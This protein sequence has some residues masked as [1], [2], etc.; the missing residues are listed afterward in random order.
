MK[1]PLSSLRV[2]VCSLALCAF[3]PA[4]VFAQKVLLLAA[5]EPS[6]AADVQA[7][8]KGS[9]VLT[10]VDVLDVRNPGSTPTLTALLAYDA[11]LT[12]S[13]YEYGDAVGL[14]NV[15]ADYV[16]RGKGVVQAVFALEATVP[17]ALGGRWSSGGYG[18]FSGGQFSMAF[19][20]SLK[21]LQPQHPIL[22]GVVQFNSGAAGFYYTN[23]T[24]SPCG[25]VV[26]TWSNDQPLAVACAGPRGG[27]SVGLNMF[28]PSSAVFSDSWLVGTDGA[29]LMANALRYAALAPIANT[30][31]AADAGA[32]QII[33]ATGPGGAAF[34]LTA[35]GSD[36]DGDTLAF[37]WAGGAFGSGNLLSGTLQP[38][39]APS[40][41]QAYTFTLTVTDGRGGKASDEV[42]V[43][44]TDTAGPVL[45]NVPTEVVN[46]P[47][48]DAATA[49]FAPV[50]AVD[51]VDG[52]RPVTC[53]PAAPY[54]VGDT[55]VTCSA[56]DTR[57]NASSASF[58]VHVP[59][60]STP[61]A[62]AGLALVRAGS[63]KYQIGFSV[64]ERATGERARFDL[65]ISDRQRRDEFR[66]RTTD[67]VAFSD[68]PAVTPGRTLQPQVDSV[69]FGGT[70]EWNGHGG[71]RYEVFAVDRGDLGFQ[72]D[73]VR[74][75]ITAP[76]GAVVAHL[77][78][79]L[80]G[81][82]IESARLRR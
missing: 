75:T 22:D 15:L 53:A 67:G 24:V 52:N 14:G 1:N 5:E 23:L 71:Y 2:A 41:S 20:L 69:L 57:G 9:G 27:R 37:S 62:M 25:L 79:A 54:P 36:A 56:S 78:G 45:A 82:F 60:V 3:T 19:G 6:W 66:A 76:G 13:E 31:P 7:K 4:S 18:A 32:D 68:D 29:L 73:S 34:S 43:I 38:P 11:V 61:G 58:T 10:Q 46:V 44:V 39:L 59:P 74:V 17:L 40:K 35:T 77:D 42:V 48:A 28:P 65:R 8:L 33:E 81:G 12:W 47:G 49:P 50:T 30:A 70:G 21:P 26:A 16:D 72:R 51:A 63:I 55:V 80:S 64:V